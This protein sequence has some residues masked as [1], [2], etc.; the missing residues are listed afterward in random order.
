MATPPKTTTP[1]RR[2][3]SSR[4]AMAAELKSP[5]KNRRAPHCRLCGVPKKGH[6]CPLQ[7]LDIA[8]RT[9]GSASRRNPQT[10]RSL[11]R[12]VRFREPIF[13]FQEEHVAGE[14][15]TQEAEGDP[16]SG[17]R[18]QIAS[19]PDSPPPVLEGLADSP[20][21]APTN[22]AGDAQMES[23]PLNWDENSLPG[24]AVSA[25]EV[26]ALLDP[27]NCVGNLSLISP[28]PPPVFN[29][30]CGL[31]ISAAEVE[32]MLDGACDDSRF[33]E[34]PTIII[35]ASSP[36]STSAVYER[37]PD[38]KA[39]PSVKSEPEGDDKLPFGVDDTLEVTGIA[40]TESKAS[41]PKRGQTPHIDLFA[42]PQRQTATNTSTGIAP[43]ATAVQK[44]ALRRGSE[45]D[46][47]DR[48]DGHIDIHAGPNAEL[49]SVKMRCIDH[50]R[51][52]SVGDQSP[53]N[54]RSR[55][56]KES[57]DTACVH[58]PGS[59]WVYKSSSHTVCAFVP[60]RRQ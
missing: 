27:T 44:R 1:R 19:R 47:I 34:E 54:V 52:L 4:A 39:K 48:W 36:K 51:W 49:L 33:L 26:A 11:R 23:T 20:L 45:H 56:M 17:E 14:A 28:T 12:S 21:T 41:A 22:T 7:T 32:T 2:R 10:R 46:A 15:T 5:T 40:T 38:F 13:S 43:I 31:L 8:T 59:P 16:T 42:P 53:W 24:S 9:P 30:S 29:I 55:A 3:P 35:T 6:R 57:K 50:R 37:L 25:E 58:S 18:R 60:H